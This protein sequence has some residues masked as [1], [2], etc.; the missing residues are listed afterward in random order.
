MIE[1]LMLSFLFV[2]SA[3]AQSDSIPVC[4]ASYLD[5]DG[6]GFG[7]TG[8]ESC[9]VTEQSLPPPTYI[10]LETGA[11]VELVRAYWDPNS[12][13]ADRNIRCEYFEFNSE[14]AVYERNPNAFGDV[15]EVGWIQ[16]NLFYHVPLA[17]TDQEQT[18]KYAL[19]NTM[20]HRDWQSIPAE[21]ASD[22]TPTEDLYPIAFDEDYRFLWIT[23]RGKLP[24]WT[25]SDGVYEGYSPLAKSPYV[26][27][28]DFANQTDS[29]VRIWS[30][31]PVCT[32]RDCN[33]QPNKSYHICHALDQR[34][35][36]P[37][38][39]TGLD[40]TA[41]E[42]L[43][44]VVV[45]LGEPNTEAAAII[46]RE[47]GLP[48]EFITEPWNYNKAIAGRE[49]YCTQ[50][51]FKADSGTYEP[52]NLDLSNWISRYVFHPYHG[53][54]FVLMSSMF[55]A[56]EYPSWWYTEKVPVQNGNLSATWIL[57]STMEKTADG[58]NAWLN[59]GQYEEC[60]ASAGFAPLASADVP[61]EQVEQT[62]D[63]IGDSDTI[64]S[65][66]AGDNN[67]ESSDHSNPSATQGHSV[68]TDSGGGGA[69]GFFWFFLV[70]PLITTSKPNRIN[71]RI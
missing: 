25:V 17:S 20:F 38:G 54:D 62:D 67:A 18:A 59:E 19:W 44:N 37:T 26:E 66:T 28:I 35:L 11:S 7:W 51:V 2:G 70:L 15:P 36:V 10:D 1:S 8:S 34:A 9:R 3:F 16:D 12:D 23:G 27:V 46:N 45:T 69:I 40:G 6:D 65:Q 53:G 68:T 47:T 5:A 55:P 30:W 24:L 64:D 58:F 48:I 61:N 42:S 31:H 71:Q 21:L 63:P 50:H 33:V 39:V 52:N 41:L 29:A 43:E 4:V 14:T 57:G 13:I 22:N 60:I 49:V 32:S 56:N